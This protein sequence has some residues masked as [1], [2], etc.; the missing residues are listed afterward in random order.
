MSYHVTPLYIAA[1]NICHLLINQ[2]VYHITLS[3]GVKATSLG[4]YISLLTG[5]EA[6]SLDTL[7]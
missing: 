1:T 4:I 7:V 5:V 3:I 2:F 6:T